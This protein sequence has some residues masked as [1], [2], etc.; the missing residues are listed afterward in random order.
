MLDRHFTT[1]NRTALELMERILGPEH[2]EVAALLVEFSAV[3]RLMKKL[4]AA[5][6]LLLKALKIREASYGP[7]HPESAACV[8][9]L[10]SLYKAFL[11]F[12]MPHVSACQQ[13]MHRFEEAVRFG[14]RDVDLRKRMFGPADVEVPAAMMNLAMILCDAGE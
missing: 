2:P 11:I 10:A 12:F 13:G 6:P 1:S 5:E 9:Q 3:L 4:T 7:F 14:S 8:T